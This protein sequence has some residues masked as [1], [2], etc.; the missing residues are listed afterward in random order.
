[1]AL[2]QA[3]QQGISEDEYLK[4]ELLSDIRHEL[5]HGEAYA[6]AG[7]SRNHHRITRNLVSALTQYLNGKPCEPFFSDMKVKVDSCFFYPDA[8][9]V[10]DDEQGH[11]YYTEKPSL[12]IEVLSKTHG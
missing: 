3:R 10:C 7:A 4:G 2:N 5:I 11:D 6:M 12:I 1:M 8:L 9:V